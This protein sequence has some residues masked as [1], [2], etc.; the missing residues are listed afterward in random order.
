MRNQLV[1]LSI[2]VLLLVSCSQKYLRSNSS[3]DQKTA[4]ID[5]AASD[6]AVVFRLIRAP[7]DERVNWRAEGRDRVHV[8]S[9]W[10]EVAAWCGVQFV[11]V[12]PVRRVWVEAGKRYVFV[13]REDALLADLIEVQD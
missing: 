9:G 8:S 2:S 4:F 11:D 3:A 7:H 12:E 6:D 1:L 10:W 5:L 13:C